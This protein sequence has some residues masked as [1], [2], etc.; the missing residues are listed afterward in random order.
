M[1]LQTVFERLSAIGYCAEGGVMNQELVL[2]WENKIR[3][4]QTSDSSVI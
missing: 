3:R 4:E 2:A 1:P